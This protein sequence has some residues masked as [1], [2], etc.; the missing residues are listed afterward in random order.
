MTRYFVF[1][2][3][4]LSLLTACSEGDNYLQKADS[5]S[6]LVNAYI[7]NEYDT[8]KS[9]DIS[10]FDTIY[11]NGSASAN[12]TLK[13]KTYFWDN[14]NNVRLNDYQFKA[15]YPKPGVYSPVFSIVDYFGDTLRDTLQIRVSTPPVLDSVNFTPKHMSMAM[16]ADSVYFA[17]NLLKSENENTYNFSLICGNDFKIDT[18]LT[19]PFYSHKQPMPEL[20]SCNWH[21]SCKNIYGIEG[22]S[23]TGAFSTAGN[24]G[25]GR[26]NGI[27]LASGISTSDIVLT[28][29]TDSTQDTLK[30]DSFNFDT[31]K[32]SAAKYT[33]KIEVPKYKDY[34]PDSVEVNLHEGF[35]LHTALRLIDKTAPEFPSLA[36]DTIP[37]TQKLILPI[38]NEGL[39]LT[40]GKRTI[41]LDNKE[42]E[43]SIDDDT[44][45]ILIPE[46]HLPICRE[47]SI[48]ITD[49]AANKASK[50]LYVC[51]QSTWAKINNDTTIT[52][53]DSL[54]IFYQELNPYNLK[55]KY[56][57]WS[58]P[59]RDIIAVP[60]PLD[61]FGYASITFPKNILNEGLH[62]MQVKTVYENGLQVFSYFNL[63]VT[64]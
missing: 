22:N 15:T 14:G 50:K 49:A 53:K 33:L 36:S 58:T 56:I 9:I 4:F 27:I 26:I 8:I 30:L 63:E 46:Y 24:S 64:R 47:L 23:L 25:L 3:I 13:L 45:Q 34:T 1:F 55:V 5:S 40:L 54:D 43:S 6:I 29:S 62:K 42:V 19:E 39:P 57:Q 32:L 12:G 11:L 38:K 31:Q 60:M 61:E 2:L 52:T 16:P 7:G 51:P 35:F 48:S 37:Y 18:I 21:V 28:L 10:T 44:L 41:S 59:Y 17:W 20:E